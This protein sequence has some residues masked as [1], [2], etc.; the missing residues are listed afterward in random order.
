M[1]IIVSD[2]HVNEALGNHYQFFDM[3]TAFE[4]CDHDLIFLGD[5][6]DLW[7]A[8]PRYESRIHHRFLNWCKE[9]KERR[10]IGFI[11]GN[12][13]YFLADES[14]DFFSWCTAGAIWQD[15]RGTVF[16]HGD[17]VNRLDSNYLF[18]RRLSK[19]S[20]S[21]QILRFFPLGPWFVKYLKARMKDT[22][23][24]FRKRLPRRELETF[25]EHRFRAGARIVFVGHFH[26]QYCYRSPAGGELH[27][28]P[29][30]LGTGAVTLF[31]P[32]QRS[33]SH[34]NWQEL[35]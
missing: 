34:R 7:I 12:H 19:N 28:V 3:L 23:L 22:N 27:T 8:L 11:E 10:T 17:Q 5:I 32:D 13:E 31:D 33:V 15:E 24:D 25:A 16:C 29:G 18:F 1:I 4:A 21:K 20:I 14:K 2:A 9:Q 30:W 6:F 26:R 35:F